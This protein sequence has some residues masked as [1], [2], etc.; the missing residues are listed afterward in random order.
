MGR[1]TT[2]INRDGKTASA[3]RI[4]NPNPNHKADAIPHL[5]DKYGKGN[6]VVLTDAELPT[7]LQGETLNIEAL[8]GFNIVDGELVKR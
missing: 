5:E 1:L 4:N 2:L 3:G 6:W 7:E 8:K